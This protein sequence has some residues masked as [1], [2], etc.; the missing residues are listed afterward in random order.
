MGSRLLKVR[1]A[2]TP[3]TSP[4]GSDTSPMLVFDVTSRSNLYSPIVYYI[5]L[6]S[7]ATERGKSLHGHCGS[8]AGR[9]DGS[10]ANTEVVRSTKN[11]SADE[12]VSVTEKWWG[13]WKCFVA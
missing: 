13:K 4:V 1:P 10:P 8:V 12:M 11:G 9:F 5:V 2:A 6:E 3:T 7:M